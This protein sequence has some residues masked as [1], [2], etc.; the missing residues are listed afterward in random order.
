MVILQK[1][2]LSSKSLNIALIQIY[3]K[4]GFLKAFCKT[5]RVFQFVPKVCTTFLKSTFMEGSE[6]AGVSPKTVASALF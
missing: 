6:K 2:P 5:Q 4:E 3:H 1:T